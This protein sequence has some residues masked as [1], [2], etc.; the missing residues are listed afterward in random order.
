ME[1][2][3][4]VRV[5]GRPL[6]AEID[7]QDSFVH[8]VLIDFFHIIQMRLG[9]I[10]R[11]QLGDRAQLLDVVV[12]AAAEMHGTAAAMRRQDGKRV[13]APA[14]NNG[15]KSGGTKTHP[16]A[17]KHHPPLRDQSALPDLP[18]FSRFPN[19]V[20]SALTLSVYAKNYSTSSVLRSSSTC[21]DM[22]VSAAHVECVTLTA[23]PEH[24]NRFL[25]FLWPCAIVLSLGMKPTQKNTEV[26]LA[27]IFL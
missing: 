20:S 9:K 7:Q 15:R 10:N 1:S 27:T 12:P 11:C 13:S 17:S 23:R 19:S 21:T 8:G 5:C 22:A 6:P 14:Q 26:F 18:E 4:P 25:T 24:E 3:G 16:T 2:A